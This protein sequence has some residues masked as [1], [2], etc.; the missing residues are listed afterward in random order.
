MSFDD[1]V[2]RINGL[3]Q[4]SDAKDHQLFT[5]ASSSW[6]YISFKI[7]SFVELCDLYTVECLNNCPTYTWS[8]GP[9]TVI[10]TKTEDILYDKTYYIVSCE[11]CSDVDLC[12]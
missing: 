9:C 11:P 3:I 5:H 2:Y 6:T 7:H 10:K 8:K 12:S 4:L 1:R